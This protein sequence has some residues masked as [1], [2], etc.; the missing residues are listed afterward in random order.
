[1]L[2][3]GHAENRV[4]GRSAA[5]LAAVAGL[6]AVLGSPAAYGQCSPVGYIGPATGS[7]FNPANWTTR[8]TAPF[9]GP[10]TTSESGFFG[11]AG[12]GGFRVVR[13]DENPTVNTGGVFV[14]GPGVRFDMLGTNLNVLGSS[15]ECFEF[16]VGRQAD[17]LTLLDVLGPGSIGVNAL[18]L[19]TV[20]GAD[21]TMILRPNTQGLAP[22]LRLGLDSQGVIIIGAAGNGKLELAGAQFITTTPSGFIT[23]GSGTDANGTISMT[24]GAFADLTLA[25]LRIGSTGRGRFELLSDAVALTETDQPVRIGVRIGGAGELAILGPNSVFRETASPVEVGPAGKGRV[26]IAEGSELIAP[27]IDVDRAGQIISSGKVRDAVRV[28]GGDFRADDPLQNGFDRVTQINGPFVLKSPDPRTGQPTGGSLTVVLANDD[29]QP[30]RVEVDGPAILGGT[31]RVVAPP[32]FDPPIGERF[33]VLFADQGLDGQFDAL[34]R[35]TFP[36]G[37]TVEIDYV[38]GNRVDLGVVRAEVPR[39][40]RSRPVPSA[41]SLDPRVRSA[42]AADFNN[43]GLQ[44]LAVV[45]SQGPGEPALFATV[46]NRGASP[47][48]NWLGFEQPQFFDTRGTDPVRVVAA[49]VNDDELVDLLV[50]NR[51][52]GGFQGE[53]VIRL[54]S[55]DPRELFP[56]VDPRNAIRTS[57]RVTGID[58]TD[59]NGDGRTDIVITTDRSQIVPSLTGKI[60]VGTNLGAEDD[61]DIDEVETGEQPE[62]ITSIQSLAQPGSDGVVVASATD[63]AVGIHWPDGR[64]GYL[65]PVDVNVGADPTEV[66]TGDINNDGVPDIVTADSL[67]GTI[68]LAIGIP[69]GGEPIFDAAILFAA[70]EPQD[71]ANPRSPVILDFDGDG[72]GDISYIADIG[73]V[74][75]VRII[76]QDDQGPNGEVQ[77]FEPMDVATDSANPDPVELEKGDLDGDGSEDLIVVHTDSAREGSGTESD[78]TAYL[79]GTCP[80]EYAGDSSLNIDDVLEFLNLFANGSPEADLMPPFGTFNIDDVL[81]FLDGFATGCP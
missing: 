42:V 13:F 62:S 52:E 15:P 36:S 22:S 18:R 19:G 31:L 66:I 23:L 54:N 1:M 77:F 74:P 61:F 3:R 11:A 33:T 5:S 26:L 35:P 53:V 32:G 29:S 60:V 51:I 37:N 10:P 71:D 20:P 2:V 39:D 46:L 55:G 16:A 38:N 73:G 63:D 9:F 64:G 76:L 47:S 7:W 69:T 75:T 40:T 57:G 56:Q 28:L 30:S 6:S 59:V 65:P 8:P 4:S 58:T 72:D 25:A 43:D 27:H 80:F 14:N 21:G 12:T 44:D 49:D 48:G 78:V 24:D 41:F 79:V 81:F 17:V 50:L 70:A 45:V 34:Q 68:S 67:G